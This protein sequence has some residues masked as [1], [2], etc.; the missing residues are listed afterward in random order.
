MNDIPTPSSHPCQE[1]S[2]FSAFVSRVE[3][4]GLDAFTAKT[5]ANFEKRHVT[6]FRGARAGHFGGLKRWWGSAGR[7]IQTTFD[8]KIRE[9]WRCHDEGMSSREIA[10]ELGWRSHASVLYHLKRGRP[11]PEP[12]RWSMPTEGTPMKALPEELGCTSLLQRGREI[13]KFAVIPKAEL[14]G[15][16][17][18][19]IAD[20]VGYSQPEI[21]GLLSDFADLQ[22][23]IKPLQTAAL[24]A[25]RLHATPL[26]R[27][28]AA[29]SHRGQIHGESRLQVRA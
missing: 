10:R 19:A 26:Q 16:T 29:G 6:P 25:D 4:W 1:N 9:L 21:S 24:F 15:W 7:D 5:P 23:L 27:L 18:E 14:A 13:E 17:Q 3:S 28:E 22:K 20:A 2:S 11:A 8:A 12:S